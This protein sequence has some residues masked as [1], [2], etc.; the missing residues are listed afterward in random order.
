[1][2]TTIKPASL[3]YD[4]TAGLEEDRSVPVQ[5]I[6]R[7]IL[8]LKVVPVILRSP[9]SPSP[10]LLLKGPNSSVKSAYNAMPSSL[11]LYA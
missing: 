3:K 1:M 4:E 11:L 9:Q 7:M 5:Q 6:M 10:F 8:I 2:N